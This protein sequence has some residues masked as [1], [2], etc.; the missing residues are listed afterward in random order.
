MIDLRRKNKNKI[1]GSASSWRRR[2]GFTLMEMLVSIGIVSLIFTVL[3]SN[4]RKTYEKLD[5]KNQVYNIVL[6]IR[7]A[8]V[9]SL[10]VKGFTKSGSTTYNTSYGVS[11]GPV[12]PNLITFFTDENQNSR[13]DAGETHTDFPFIRGIYI[14]KVCV[15]KTSGAEDCGAP[16]D[17]IDIVFKRPNPDAVMQF[18]DNGG[19][20]VASRVPPAK[21]YLSS[22]SGFTASV[23]VDSTGGVTVQ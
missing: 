3:L 15:T 20:N 12:A 7:Q 9:Y 14:Q 22:P 6:Y 21:I 16:I 2:D 8:Q 10:S 5:L 23:K 11:L 13:Y 4:N 18:L 17:H 1:T 19:N